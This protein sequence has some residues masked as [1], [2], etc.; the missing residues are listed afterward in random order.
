MKRIL[1]FGGSGQDGRI[2][3]QKLI[4]LGHV[5][6]CVVTRL[7]PAKQVAGAEYVSISRN[8]D[9]KFLSVILE[10]QPTEVYNFASLSSVAACAENP[11]HSYEVNFELVQSIYKCASIYA[12][13]VNHKVKL[14][15][16][17]SSE[18]FKTSKLPLNELSELEPLSIYGQHK[19]MAH[20]FLESKKD[21]VSNLEISNL[22]FFNHESFLRTDK[23]V[24]QKIAK[25]SA[26]LYLYK[27]TEIKFGN[28]DTARDWGCAFDYM[29]A[30]IKVGFVN[31]SENYVVASGKLVSIVQLLNHSLN[32]IGWSSDSF[33]F[34]S[35]KSL[36]RVSDTPPLKGDPGKMKLQTG[37][38]PSRS[39][40]Q[41]LEEMIDYQIKFT[42]DA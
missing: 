16:A 26:Q 36:M 19:K 24:S 35:D 4:E 5:V 1:I 40:F 32:Y 23:F 14:I 21:K 28:V 33:E 13:R 3:S 22:I 7:D 41:A 18:M 27:F 42:R 31:S 30:A 25:A 17:G 9:D 15:H 10:F 6:L 8:F 29:D 11:N 39:I 38:A 34:E 37:W 20:D 2:L 12:T